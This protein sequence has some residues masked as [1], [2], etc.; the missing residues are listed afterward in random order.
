MASVKLSLTARRQPADDS[1]VH[2]D[3]GTPF[4]R[5]SP[6][7]TDFHGLMDHRKKALPRNRKLSVKHAGWSPREPLRRPGAPAPGRE[8]NRQL[9]IE[10]G[11]A[12]R[13]RH[14]RGNTTPPADPTLRRGFGRQIST[15]LEPHG[16]GAWGARM[17]RRHSDVQRSAPG[18]RWDRLRSDCTPGAPDARGL[19]PL[20]RP[21]AAALR[22][23]MDLPFE[24]HA[25]ALRREMDPGGQTARRS[26]TGMDLRRSNPVPKPLR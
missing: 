19:P 7:G 10:A 22:E 16:R 9:W 15:A 1:V 18:V 17:H 20:F 26:A 12:E 5:H 13:A 4:A 25:A 11:A 3:R 14:R 8:R 21:R 23:E 6:Q 24:P 2:A